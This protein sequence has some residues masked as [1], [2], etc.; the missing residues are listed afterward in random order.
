M[1]FF[2]VR[3][4]EAVMVTPGKGALPVVTLPVIWQPATVAGCATGTDSAVG[5]DGA[6]PAAG[7]LC[8]A[9]LAKAKLPR[10][11]SSSPRQKM[12]NMEE[13]FRIKQFSYS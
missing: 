9:T 4:L 6:A 3:E 1:D 5:A 2:P 12:E 11:A 10:T 13:R 7:V 8:A